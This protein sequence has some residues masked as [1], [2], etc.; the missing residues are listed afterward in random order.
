MQNVG[1]FMLHVGHGYYYS[2]KFLFLL[3]FVYAFSFAVL[4][5][6]RFLFIFT[7][8]K[9]WYFSW[10]LKCPFGCLVSVEEIFY[11]T[12]CLFVV[13]LLFTNPWIP[14]EF[15]AVRL[16]FEG[17]FFSFPF[18]IESQSL[19]IYLKFLEVKSEC[20]W[21]ESICEPNNTQEEV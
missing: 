16:V 20:F 15:R 6:F 8:G 14:L 13:W 7:V 12:F 9:F 21:L 19:N 2:N 11:W 10:P 1:I 18:L 3:S 4:S 17:I 5:Y